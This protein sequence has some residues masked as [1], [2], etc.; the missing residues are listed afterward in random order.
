M[1]N[2]VMRMKKVMGPFILTLSLLSLGILKGQTTEKPV[3]IL[4]LGTQHL[5]YID[6]FEPEMLQGVIS[7]LDSYNFDV[8]CIE[9]M[10]AQLLYD[11]RSRQDSS[12]D[13]VLS[14]FGGDR[15]D[16][17]DKAQLDYQVGFHDAQKQIY[18][19]LSEKKELDPEDRADL[20]KLYLA[21]ADKA[22]AALQYNYLRKYSDS[23]TLEFLDPEV[24]KSMEDLL[25]SHNEVYALALPIAENR[26]LNRIASIDDFQDEALLLKHFPSFIGEYMDNQ[27]FFKDLPN[28]PVFVKSRELEKAC[29]E[30][31]DLYDLYLFLN[32]AEFQ[33]QD[34]K[35]QWQI[36]LESDFPSGSDRARYALWEMR[37]LQISANI[38]RES[39]FYPGKRMLVIIGASHKSFLEKYLRQIP[40]VQLLEFD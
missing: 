8:V 23:S 10:P 2:T 22:S 40:S 24:R 17:A 26:D 4:V 12:F 11:I 16:M 3:E 5:S 21:T 34:F 18:N 37:N 7:K 1:T 9:N 38:V 20:I 28:Q 39:A 35:A 29:V 19:I 32:S 25:H 14:S 30:K 27:D 15:L 13:G 36:W 6:G 31:R 33:K